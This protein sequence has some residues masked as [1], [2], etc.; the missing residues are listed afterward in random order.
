MLFK[1][2]DESFDFDDVVIDED[3]YC[4]EEHAVA[5]IKNSAV[6]GNDAAKILKK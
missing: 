3:E 5:P 4:H 6:A 2:L 1:R